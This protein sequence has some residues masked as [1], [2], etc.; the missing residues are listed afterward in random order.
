MRTPD[1]DRATPTTDGFKSGCTNATRLMNDESTGGRG[2]ENGE[3]IG[4]NGAAGRVS[5]RRR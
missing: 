4:P 2:G 5:R 1:M 3:L